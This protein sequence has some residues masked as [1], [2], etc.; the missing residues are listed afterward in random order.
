M[1]KLLKTDCDKHYCGVY[2]TPDPSFDLSTLWRYRDGSDILICSDQKETLQE[3]ENLPSATGT[4]RSGCKVYF[5]PDSLVSPLYLSKLK[6]YNVDIKRVVKPE[7]ADII[8]VSSISPYCNKIQITSDYDDNDVRIR[9]YYGYDRTKE[10]LEQAKHYCARPFYFAMPAQNAKLAQKAM[11]MYT[12]PDKIVYDQDFITYIFQ[13]LPEIDD[14]TFNN[15][16]MM[17]NNSDTKVRS[18]AMTCLQYYNFSNHI[19]DL[20]VYFY[21]RERSLC[22]SLSSASLSERFVAAAVN[23]RPDYKY[24]YRTSPY[25]DI[26][27]IVTKTFSN[28]MNTQSK[29]DVANKIINRYL[30]D[31]R[32]DYYFRE[33]KTALNA[34]GYT[35]KLEQMINDQNGETESGN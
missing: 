10:D 2:T 32:N 18:L 17:L 14:E 16:L 29:G 19:Y 26:V 24:H 3:F 31:I 23:A 22:N 13:F 15:T 30:D 12:Y 4:I 11:L 8:V 33:V 28:P 20:L 6:D 21:T 25:D 27:T 35:I 9:I 1:L 34:I 5:A 7:K